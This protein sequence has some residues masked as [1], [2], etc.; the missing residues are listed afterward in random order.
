MGFFLP[1][2]AKV[3]AGRRIYSK[4]DLPEEVPRSTKPQWIRASD[5]SASRTT[6]RK[7]SKECL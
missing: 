4:E 5:P 1:W 7:D 3:L 2:K 6:L